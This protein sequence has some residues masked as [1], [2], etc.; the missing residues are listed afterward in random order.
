MIDFVMTD[1]ASDND[2]MLEE[3]DISEKDVLNCNP[4]ILLCITSIAES[5]YRD[6]ESSLGVHK[7]IGEGAL[8]SWKKSNSI[9]FLGLNAFSKLFSPC[10]GQESVN[11]YKDYKKFLQDTAS[12]TSN[13]LHDVA[14]PIVSK[15]FL[16]FD[17]N[18][19]GRLAN[20]STLFLQHEAVIRAFLC[21]K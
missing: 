18:R 14:K 9:W 16:G 7:L 1:R 12:D 4:Y 8:S 3:L 17:S 21:K 20:L 5:V 15:P 2:T 10:K 6:V 13:P 11:I 19:F